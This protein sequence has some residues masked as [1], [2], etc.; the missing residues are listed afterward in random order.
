M[1]VRHLKLNVA[2]TKILIF[3]FLSFHLPIFYTSFLNVSFIF[4]LLKSKAWV[5]LDYFF[6]LRPHIQSSVNLLPLKHPRNPTTSTTLLLPPR[7]K[8]LWSLAW[9]ITIDAQLL[10]SLS[11]L[12][13]IH[14]VVSFWLSSQGDAFE[15]WIWS[16]S[17]PSSGFL[18]H[19]RWEPRSLQ[20][21]VRPYTIWPCCH[22]DL[23]SYFSPSC[24]FWGS[25]TGPIALLHNHQSLTCLRPL[26]LLY[27][28]PGILYIV[29]PLT[30]SLTSVGSLLKCQ[31][32]QWGL[33]KI[34]YHPQWFYYPLPCF[35]DSINP[36]YSHIRGKLRGARTYFLFCSWL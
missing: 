25:H 1:S 14:P 30:C 29:I 15:M 10:S 3:A 23:I 13:S 12:P 18:C 9:I 21:P 28:L 32:Y 17:K 22:S 36:H 4:L 16:C 33:F 8:P 7:S 6:P 19:L 5:F 34:T 2:K 27:P 35:T 26:P 11:P 20:W 24:S 31:S